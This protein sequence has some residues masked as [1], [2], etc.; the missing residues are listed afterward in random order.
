MAHQQVIVLKSERDIAHMRQA[1]RIVARALQAL[2]EAVRPGITTAELDAI[3]EDIIASE[4]AIPSFKGYRGYPAALCAS[5]NEQV[6]HGIPRKRA[7]K[8]GDIISMD[9]GAIHKGYHGDASITLP[10]GR[11]NREAQRLIRTTKGALRAGVAQCQPGRRVR[12]ISRAIQ[13]YAESRGYSVVRDYV[14]HGIGR[15]MH[16]PPQIPNF[17]SAEHPDL[18]TRLKA[19]MT[20]ALEPMLNIGG[21]QTRVLEDMW[22]VVTADGSLSAHFEHTVL[23]SENGPVILTEL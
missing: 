3:A 18:A 1:G 22:T 23:V 13:E 11:V 12:D 7:L 21:P 15:Q 17:V 20:L 19:G 4:K 6:V 10:V 14:G 8:E 9:L 2:R 16:Q 5:V